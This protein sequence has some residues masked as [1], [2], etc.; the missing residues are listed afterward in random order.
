MQPTG[1]PLPRHPRPPGIDTLDHTAG[2]GLAAIADPRHRAMVADV[3]ADG[4]VEAMIDFTGPFDPPVDHAQARASAD[5]LSAEFA[6]WN[7]PVPAATIR[8]ITLMRALMVPLTDPALALAV[9]RIWVFTT[10]TDDVCSHDRAEA[11]S[12]LQAGILPETPAM[13]AHTRFIRH[14]FHKIAPF[15]DPV[16]LA[17]SK[18][19]FYTAI[20][21]VLMEADFTPKRVTRSTATTSAFSTASPNSGSPP[22]SSPTPAWTPCGTRP[23]GPPS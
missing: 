13:S 12:V 4:L 3:L 5:L 16:F 10:H 8:H 17:A 21:G 14:M 19:F 23:S 11:E 2:R 22:C 9:D 20:T 15:C 6:A 7:L 18:T 1:R